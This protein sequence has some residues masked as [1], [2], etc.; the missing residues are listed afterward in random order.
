M[1]DL[2]QQIRA[3]LDGWLPEMPPGEA[4]AMFL[5]PAHPLSPDEIERWQKEFDD[6]LG[7]ESLGMRILPPGPRF[8]PGFEQMRDAILAALELHKSK[9]DGE[10]AFC[11]DEDSI[12]SWGELVWYHEDAPCPTVRTIAEKLGI[13]AQDA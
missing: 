4:P 12:S 10:C 13:E 11:V 3:R 6:L 9:D 8:Y 7:G 1:A 2:D 5:E